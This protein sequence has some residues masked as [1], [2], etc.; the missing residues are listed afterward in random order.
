MVILSNKRYVVKDDVNLRSYL[1]H[2]VREA[3]CG[4]RKLL[5]RMEK[6]NEQQRSAFPEHLNADAK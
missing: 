1:S 4:R 6:I 2:K 3:V 5:E